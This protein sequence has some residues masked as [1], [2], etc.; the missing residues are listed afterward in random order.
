MRI[1]SV[2]LVILFSTAASANSDKSILGFSNQDAATQLAQEARFDELYSKQNVRDWME[3]MSAH[4]HHVGSPYGKEV[5]E[6]IASKFTEWGYDTEIETYYV[7]F[8]TPRV[9][10]LE[11]VSPEPYSA[12][13]QEPL[14]D[15]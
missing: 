1:F 14:F 3:Y 2:L 5:A 4:P 10:V 13:L 6:F 8:P 7:L 11:V 9:R 15:V 12:R